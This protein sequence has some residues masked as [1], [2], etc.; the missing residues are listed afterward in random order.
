[1][2]VDKPK[3]PKVSGLRPSTTLEVLDR[4]FRVYRDNFGLVIGLVAIAMV[5]L[6][7][8]NIFSSLYASQR[9]E[10][11]AIST[12][13]YSSSSYLNNMLATLA[14]PLVVALIAGFVQGLLVNAPLTYIAS[15]RYLG[16]HVTIGQA[17]RAV[18]GRL[19]N[20]GV[21]LILFYVVLI[22]LTATAFLTVAVCIGLGMIGLVVYVGINFYAFLVPVIVLERGGIAR[23]IGRAWF[24]AKSRFWPLFWLT[25][26]VF[27]TTAVIGFAFS[28]TQAAIVGGTIGSAS[29]RTSQISTIIFQAIIAMFVVPVLPLAYTMMYYDTRT[30][31]EGLDI[32]LAAVGVDEPRPA[33]VA[34]PP[35]GPFMERKDWRALGLMTVVGLAP[36]G[37]YLCLIIVFIGSYSLFR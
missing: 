8:V 14:V 22:A 18:V 32:A 19:P 9:I 30:R 15:E 10:Q 36:I 29:Y 13:R 28:I 7:A 12:T 2:D 26:A 3:K 24:L 11:L 1:M 31:I 25:L 21:S 4:A 34:S 35:P 27:V 37:L 5:P 33:D 6:T 16:R 20:L 23:S 17:Y